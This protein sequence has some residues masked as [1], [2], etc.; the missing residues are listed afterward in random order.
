MQRTRKEDYEEDW[1]GQE[2]ED[3]VELEND[4]EG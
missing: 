4:L 3:D 1:S 2:D